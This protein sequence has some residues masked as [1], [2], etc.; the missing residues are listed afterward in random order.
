MPVQPGR[1]QTPGRLATTLNLNG[2]GHPLI[3]TS[4]GMCTPEVNT[5]LT[6]GLEAR[7]PNDEQSL[8]QGV[9]CLLHLHPAH[10]TLVPRLFP[11]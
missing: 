9:K 1:G 2:H 7:H 10:L 5:R 4:S 3:L 6:V 11:S 8:N